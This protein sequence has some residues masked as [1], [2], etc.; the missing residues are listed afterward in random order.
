MKQLIVILVA[1]CLVSYADGQKRA[2]ALA[3]LYKIRNV[4]DPQFSP[5][6]KKIAFIV[7]EDELAGGKTRA[8]I[9]VMD[10][11]GGNQRRLTANTGSDTHPR[12]SPDGSSLLF[13]STRNKGAQ[14]WIIPLGGGEPKQLTDFSAGVGNPEW[15]KDGAGIVFDS[16]VYPECGADNDCNRHTGESWS[17]GPLA[18]HMADGLLY[19][20]WT[21]W[22][23]GKRKHILMFSISSGTYTDLTPG[24]F[25]SPLFSLGGV[26]FDLSPD[27]KEIGFVSQRDGMDASSTNKDLWT[28]TPSGGAPVNLTS[29][30]KAYDGD[31]A[32]SPDGRYIAYRTQKVPGYESDKFRLALYDRTTREKRILSEKFDN[33]V[34]EIAWGPDSKSIYF[35]AD[36]EGRVPLYRLDIESGTLRKIYESGMI[37]AFNLS[38]DGKTAAFV[39]RTVGEP[40][41]I[42]SVPTS[43]G[44]ARRL[45]F[46]N[47][48]LA[49]AVDIRP[50]Q[51][52][53]I[54]SPTGRR[55][56]TFIV[57]PHD[58][59]PKKKYPLIV[60]VHGGPQMQWADA[61]RGDWQVY[62][63]SG[64][65]VA[66]PNP[67]GSTGYGQEFTKGI[68]RDWGGKVFRDVMAVTDSLANL[69][70]V[71]KDRLGAMGWSYGGTMMMWLEGHTT[72]FRAI[73][74]MMGV[75]DFPSMH[76]ATE[77][78]WFPEY[79]LGGTPW[80]SDLYERWSPNRSV[81]NF[82]TPC[83][84]I[85]G[86]RD[87]R[88]PY[89][90]SLEFFTDLQEMHV[91][92][93]LIVFSND[94]HWPDGV[95]SMP[96]YYNAHLDWFHTYLGGDPAPY[97]MT[98]MLRNQAMKDK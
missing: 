73:A 27:G 28:V 46:F 8:A 43:E 63:G 72:R 3:D 75:Y 4:E 56:H 20:H 51:E 21:A 77:E 96:F 53:W 69:P 57:T 89:T 40:R 54:N 14:A 24:E 50:A 90:Q 58:F 44:T 98:K 88:V 12:W 93:R 42:W 47:K 55:I 13:L 10:S 17:A 38:P 11:D 52:L 2:F 16:E 5:D 35:T 31:P 84:V 83:L 45:T 15:S 60:N 22:R 1:A 82:K 49:E 48:E 87:Y 62:P 81:K 76:G 34:D 18:A 61:F 74:C 68:S 95:K 7:R 71:D 97:D 78:L 30:N 26:G 9:Y 19:R 32:Y 85:T 66:F 94:G 64:Y 36:V 37:D 25:D 59:D 67:T 6:G 79:E 86:E 91:P 65:I 39:R 80:T 33:W 29:E 41:E 23:D 92:S 70:Y